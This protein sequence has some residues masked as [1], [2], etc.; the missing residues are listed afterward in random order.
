MKTILTLIA[1]LLVYHSAFAASFKR[2]ESM[3]DERLNRLV[4]IHESMR[5]LHGHCGEAGKLQII[6]RRINEVWENTVK[7]AVYFSNTGVNAPVRNMQAQEI[8]LRTRGNLP[9]FLAAA[10]TDLVNSD[11]LSVEDRRSLNHFAAVLG[12]LRGDYRFYV[13]GHQNAFGPASFAV[14]VDLVQAEILVLQA[15]FC[16]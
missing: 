8:D 12:T 15:N 11:Q 6:A 16:N 14:V 5:H 7:Q 9:T 10:F 3:E 4:E 13:G 2:V 1:T